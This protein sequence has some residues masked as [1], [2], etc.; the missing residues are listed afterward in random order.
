MPLADSQ[1]LMS[2]LDDL[3][4]VT[5]NRRASAA[6]HDRRQ[7]APAR[8]SAG[9]ARQEPVSEG[10]EGR[11]LAAGGAGADARRPAGAASLLQAP[12]FSFASEQ[13][14]ARMLGVVPGA[15]SPFAA[16]NDVHGEVCVVLEQRVLDSDACSTVT[17]SEMT[18]R[19][20]IATQRPAEISR[21]GPASAAHHRSAS[22]GGEQLAVASPLAGVLAVNVKV[23]SATH[24]S[25][26]FHS[27]ERETVVTF[28]MIG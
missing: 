20:T 3:G 13:E 14:L 5:R 8:R 15:V 25:P 26:P 19:P 4:I 22:R 16:I 21:A 27:L 18:A 28:I 1:H 24:E 11:L 23:A 10:Q 12:R 17:R 2:M 7:Q 6:A 9:R